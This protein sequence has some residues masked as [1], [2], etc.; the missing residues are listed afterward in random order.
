M[1]AL[2]TIALTMFGC[3]FVSRG[4]I[5]LIESGEGVSRGDAANAVS[6]TVNSVVTNYGFM[7]IWQ[8]DREVERYCTL[9]N[10]CTWA[11]EGKGWL[12]P[13]IY[14]RHLSDERIQVG[15]EMRDAMNS[16]QVEVIT[17]EIAEKLK[18]RFGEDKVVIERTN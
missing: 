1:V 7:E 13:W 8:S 9:E 15:I 16:K 2:L 12:Q 11:P 10:G 6:L 3:H 18:K 5:V 4:K 17:N 14:I